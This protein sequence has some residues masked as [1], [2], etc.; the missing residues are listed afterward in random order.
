MNEIWQNLKEALEASEENMN[1]AS[2]GNKAAGLRLRKNIKAMQALLKDLRAE[3]L[4]KGD[5]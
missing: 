3:S 1:K 5:S 4:K 2:G